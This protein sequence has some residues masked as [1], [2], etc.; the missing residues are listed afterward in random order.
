MSNEKIQLG[1]GKWGLIELLGRLMLYSYWAVRPNDK[2]YSR[3]K[4]GSV[5]NPLPKDIPAALIKI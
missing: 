1:Q 5:R 4:C 3:N 2:F